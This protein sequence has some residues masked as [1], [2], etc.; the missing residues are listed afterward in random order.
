M[1][2]TSQQNNGEPSPLANEQ[3]SRGDAPDG[4]GL[5]DL[6][7]HFLALEADGRSVNDR[8]AKVFAKAKADGFDPKALRTAFRQRLRE[9]EN[10]KET[11]KH[12]EHT[13]SYLVILRSEGNGDDHT[14]DSSPASAQAEP[15]PDT[16]ARSHA[17]TR[18][19]EAASHEA[20]GGLI[21]FTDTTNLRAGPGCANSP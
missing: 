18:T 19:R 17:H 8:K 6:F 15:A 16:L 7:R 12:D 1:K 4:S 10:P 21:G 13:D 14:S 2:T 20:D 3:Q 11:A 9:M 5:R